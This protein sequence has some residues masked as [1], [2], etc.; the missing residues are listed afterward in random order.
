MKFFLWHIGHERSGIRL[1]NSLAI[2]FL[3]SSERL[4]CGLFI[5]IH[6]NRSVNIY[7]LVIYGVDNF[8]FETFGIILVCH[9]TGDDTLE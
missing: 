5:T 2:L 6:F 7:R 1:D 3:S 9:E 8:E 4:C